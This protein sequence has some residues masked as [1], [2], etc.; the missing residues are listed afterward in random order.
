MKS[1]NDLTRQEVVVLAL[2]ARGLRNSEIADELVIT[3]KTVEAH[4]SRIFNKLGVSS[5]TQAALY[6]IHNNLF[7]PAEM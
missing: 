4:V 7:Q 5:R 6:A 1:V 2:L 3:T